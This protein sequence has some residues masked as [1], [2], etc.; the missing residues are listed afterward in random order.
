MY[1]LPKLSY[2]FQNL[3]PFIDTYAM[4]IHYHKYH[5]YYLNYENHRNRYID[6]F[7]NITDFTY[8]SEIFNNIIK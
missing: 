6:N 5:A 2:L 7:F 1:N 8:A 4:G 3:E